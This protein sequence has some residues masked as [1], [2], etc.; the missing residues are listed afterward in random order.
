MLAVVVLVVVLVLVL[1][2]VVLVLVLMTDV[3]L[4]IIAGLLLLRK[5]VVA[6]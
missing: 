2:L 3:V 6:K 1:E 5:M 4:F